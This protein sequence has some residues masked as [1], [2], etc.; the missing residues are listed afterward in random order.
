MPL[1][2]EARQRQRIVR[3]VM[4]QQVLYAFTLN[5]PTP[6]PPQSRTVIEDA[7]KSGATVTIRG[8]TRFEPGPWVTYEGYLGYWCAPIKD[9]TWSVGVPYP[10]RKQ[11]AVI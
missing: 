9:G 1:D 2:K 5:G 11:Q 10:A 3:Q 8:K 4:Q 6:I 7:G